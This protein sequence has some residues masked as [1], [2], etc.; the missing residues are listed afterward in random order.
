[1]K[2]LA[3]HRG[4]RHRN[5]LPRLKVKEILAW[6]DAHKEQTGDWPERLSGTV[7]G[8]PGET[9]NAVDLALSR[10]TRGLR[11]GETLAELLAR[12]RGRRHK[13]EPPEL[14]I[15]QILAWAEAY[16]TLY[17][18]WPTAHTG[19]IGATGETW[20]A[21]DKALRAGTRGIPGGSSLARLV[22]QH[23]KTQGNYTPFRR[24]KRRKH[25]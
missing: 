14:G 23:E 8:A 9:W 20:L 4:Y 2:L 25:R 11:G 12:Y 15:D 16:R 18:V 10:G 5:Y 6:A 13:Q 24:H 7:P 17:G 21:I 22:R 19:A 3:Q 1:M